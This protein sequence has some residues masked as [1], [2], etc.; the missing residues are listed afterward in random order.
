[1]GSVEERVDLSKHRDEV[2]VIVIPCPA[3]GHINPLLQFAKHLAHH[4]PLKLTLPLI[5][6][7]NTNDSNHSTVQYQPLTPSLT[8][9]HIPLLPYQGPDPEPLHALWE[10]RQEAIRLHLIHLL[11]SIPNVACVVFDSIFPW[12]LDLLKQFGVFGAAFFTQSCAVN[13]I[14]YNVYKGWLDVPLEEPLVSLDGLPPLRPSDFPSF[15]SNRVK[16]P[17]YLSFLTGQFTR[18]SDVDWIFTNT[19]DG[20]E[21]EEVKWIEGQFPFKNIGPMVPSIYLDGQLQNDKDYG[22]SMFESNNTDCTM[23]WL[24]SKDPKS[25]IYVSFGSAAELEKEQMEELAYGLKLTNKFFFWVVRESEIH[26]LPHNFIKETAEEGLVVNW[27]S[28]LQVL[29]HQSV[30]CFIT[31]CGWNSTLEALSLGVPMVA[32]AQWLDQPTNAKYVEDVWKIGKRVRMEENGICGREEIEFCVNE[33]MEGGEVNGEIRENLRKWRE[34]AKAA[35]D[36]A[37][38][39]HQN[40]NYFVE[41][42]VNKTN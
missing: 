16:Y 33:V 35:M 20:L 36:E 2:E 21:P 40:I 5:L 38:S 25:V 26:K 42:L 10:R 7:N 29:A 30:G 6:T 22:V 41:Q 31:H 9:H 1:M 8:I 24:D 17:D 11:T 23:K 39:S 28:Q 13:A 27:C 4:P 18:L 32:M 14:Y 15:I 37:G 3:Q 12:V 19:F 34:L